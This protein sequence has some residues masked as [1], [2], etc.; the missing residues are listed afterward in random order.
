MHVKWER[1]KTNEAG[2]GAQYQLVALLVEG[3][4]SD[5]NEQARVLA[6]LGSIQERFLTIR[7]SKTRAFHQGLFWF[8]A[9]KK[10]EEFDLDEETHHTLEYQISE[11]V[12]RPKDDWALWG[13]TCIPH[14]D[15]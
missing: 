4:L 7:I 12:P 5:N 1:Q 15:C 6:R 10:L 3:H 14:I 8:K 2:H 9:D 13:V 11:K